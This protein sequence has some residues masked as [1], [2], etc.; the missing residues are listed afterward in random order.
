VGEVTVEQTVA[1]APEVLYA[2]VSD[3]TRMGEWSPETTSCRW[4]GAA[5][6]ATPGAK[7]RG[8]NRDGWRRW[9]TTC[10]VITADADQR[11]AFDV[12]LGPL[13]V[14][15]WTYDFAPTG[16]GCVVTETWHDRRAAW[17]VRVSPIVMG[18]PDREQHNRDSMRM[19][20]DRL[21]S[22]AETAAPSAG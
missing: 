13:P 18:V 7:F 21:R 1:A 15:R 19:T 4:L 10:T 22:F 5:T 8:T 9:F 11:F 12:D 14:S 2:L 17:M 6:K 20:L 3:V 16:N